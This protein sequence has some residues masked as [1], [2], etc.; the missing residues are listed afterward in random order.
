MADER[1]NGPQ[2]WAEWLTWLNHNTDPLAIQRVLEQSAQAF[3][4]S[5]TAQQAIARIAEAMAAEAKRCHKQGHALAETLQTWAKSLAGH[6]T[7]PPPLGPFPRQQALLNDL[8]QQSEA[9][10]QALV[11][12]LESVTTLAERCTEA[13]RKALQ[14]DGDAANDQTLEPE[15]L[16]E[17][18]SAVAEPIYEDWLDQPD[19]QRS[20]AALTNAWSALV[21]S[22]SALLDRYLETLGLPSR[23]AIDDLA[24]EL[25]R[26]RR[27]QREAINALRAEVATLREQQQSHEPS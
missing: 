21:N 26:Q 25:Q 11:A 9:Y 4:Q 18:W 19:T 10:Q 22:L 3:E 17:R 5:A 6:Q 2:D 16:L 1:G 12:H 7:P 14:A 24:A 20:I 23:R 8:N 27:R 13:F 15:E